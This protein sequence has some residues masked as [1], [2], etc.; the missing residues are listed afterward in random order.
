MRIELPHPAAGKVS[1]VASPMKLSRTPVEHR[2]APPMLG[3][4]TNE[5][6]ERSLGLSCEEIA[7]LRAGRV[8]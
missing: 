3:E 8:I 7:A 1:L 2:M 4:H 5:V 6:L